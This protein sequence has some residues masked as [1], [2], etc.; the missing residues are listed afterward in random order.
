MKAKEYGRAFAI[1]II[2]APIV[3][4]LGVIGVPIELAA[5]LG[6]IAGIILFFV[7]TI[8]IEN[9]ITKY[10][11]YESADKTLRLHKKGSFLKESVTMKRYIRTNATYKP[12]EI[13]YTGATVG[14]ITTGGIH[15]N[16]AHYETSGTRTD[17][18][19]LYFNNCQ[20]KR[21]VCD[22]EIKDHP[23]INKF[24]TDKNTLVLTYE[25]A[26]EEMGGLSKEMYKKAVVKGDLGMQYH[27]LNNQI[28]ESML[29]HNDC[30]NVLK[31]IVGK[32]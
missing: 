4:C 20:V 18:F 17:K 26:K 27:L 7:V 31:W 8:K 23:A 10:A 3:I 25:G 1:T 12:A 5:P 32:I 28:E 24:K 14:G 29:S 6:I 2:L 30:K 19:G 15:V 16:E 21:I 11:T 22:F 13:V 9:R